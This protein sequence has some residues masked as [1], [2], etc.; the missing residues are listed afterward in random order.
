MNGFRELLEEQ[1]NRIIKKLVAKLTV[2][3]AAKFSAERS[4]PIGRMVA[5]LGVS[6]NFSFKVRT[7]TNIEKRNEFRANLR[8]K[9]IYEKKIYAP[10]TEDEN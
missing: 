5:R 3:W 6:S 7:K 9:E 10:S 4:V 8:M 2:N 1:A